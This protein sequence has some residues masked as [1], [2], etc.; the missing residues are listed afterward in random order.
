MC[1]PQLLRL[2]LVSSL[3]QK[4][5]PG[6]VHIDCINGWIHDHG[7]IAGIAGHIPMR[8]IYSMRNSKLISMEY[9]R[10]DAIVHAYEKRDIG[11]TQV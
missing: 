5:T 6:G 4:L 10:N 9:R 1:A 11:H 2:V 8:H 7:D 3:H